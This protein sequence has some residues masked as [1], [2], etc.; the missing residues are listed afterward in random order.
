MNAPKCD[1]LDYIN[2]LRKKTGACSTFCPNAPSPSKVVLDLAF[3]RIIIRCKLALQA[4]RLIWRVEVLEHLVQG[5]A[6]LIE[7]RQVER[8]VPIYDLLAENWSHYKRSGIPNA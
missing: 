7:N 8:L 5:F 6:E 1:A 2:F 3:I 4:V